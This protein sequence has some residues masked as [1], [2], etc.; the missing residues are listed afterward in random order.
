MKEIEVFS[1]LISSASSLRHL[2]AVLSYAQS[3]PADPLRRYGV[4]RLADAAGPADG[5]GDRREGHRRDYAGGTRS[6]RELLPDRLRRACRRSGWQRVHGL[7]VE[8]R[9]VAQGDQR[10]VAG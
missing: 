5:A 3:Q 6:R 4:L 8:L 7:G 2:R 10:E 1:D 9:G